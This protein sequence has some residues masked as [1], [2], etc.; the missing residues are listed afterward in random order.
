MVTVVDRFSTVT[1][2]SGGP[3]YSMTDARYG[4]RGNAV[5]L[6]QVASNPAFSILGF[7]GYFTALC[8]GQD[9]TVVDD[10]FSIGKRGD[11]DLA[12][13]SNDPMPSV[14]NLRNP[15]FGDAV[16]TS[17]L[18]AHAPRG[19]HHP[20]PDLIALSIRQVMSRFLSSALAKHV[21]VVFSQSCL[22]QM[23]RVDAR[24]VV[25]A[26]GQ[27]L[28]GPFSIHQK[29]SYSMGRA[30]LS[31]EI[32]LPI[33][34]PALGGQPEPARR[35]MLVNDRPMLIDLCPKTLLQRD[36]WTAVDERRMSSRHIVS[37]ALVQ[38]T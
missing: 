21:M 7:F 3:L 30:R 16:L 37:I 15:G 13:R 17:K 20:L 2:N 19:V 14:G 26:M 28:L 22:P 23:V 34:K 8:Q 10:K 31:A 5:F 12:G 35:E 27:R 9:S 25:T 18:F 33:S 11:R 6:S 4:G 32:E 29:P 24:W 38:G 36:M 1:I